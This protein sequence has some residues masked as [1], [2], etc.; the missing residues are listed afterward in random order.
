MLTNG[1]FFEVEFD[2]E[3][4]LALREGS[5]AGVLAGAGLD[6]DDQGI[7]GLGERWGGE[8]AKSKDGE[9]CAHS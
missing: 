7:L 1:E 4:A 2:G 8:E 9:S 5:G 6:G 3:F